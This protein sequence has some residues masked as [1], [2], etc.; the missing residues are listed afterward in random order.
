M[1]LHDILTAITAEADRQIASLKERHDRTVAD[2]RAKAKAEEGRLAADLESQKQRK[3]DQLKRKAQQRAEQMRRNAVL[4]RKRA[5]IDDVYASVLQR[6]AKE[7]DAALAPLFE[8][9]LSVVADATVHSAKR[10][11][12]LLTTLAEKRGLKVGKAIEATGGFTAVSATREYDFRLE[13]IVHDLLRPATELS[14]A[15]AL[16]A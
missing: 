9:C 7:S 11:E 2:A 6:L 10:H 3:C 5:L 4:L 13:T 15:D 12:A 1:A 8:A 14:T 16:F